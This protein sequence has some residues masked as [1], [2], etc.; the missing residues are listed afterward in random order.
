MFLYNPSYASHQ[1]GILNSLGRFFE[2][3]YVAKYLEPKAGERVLDVGCNNGKFG[4]WFSEKY[5]V[6]VVGIDVNAR[7]FVENGLELRVGDA[8]QLDFP[9]NSF[10]AVVSMHTLEHLVDPRTALE[11]MYRV[12]KPQGRIVLTYPVEFIRGMTTVVSAIRAYGNPMMAR[13]MHLH[14]LFPDD[15]SEMLKR[16]YKGILIRDKHLIATPQPVWLTKQWMFK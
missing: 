1:D 9:D 8:E 14:K 3:Y 11:E 15:V 4:R 13:Q 6:S 5:D 2:K 10:D 7:P 12:T 16:G